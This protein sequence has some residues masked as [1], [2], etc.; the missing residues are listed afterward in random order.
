M[1]RHCPH[2]CEKVKQQLS[3]ERRMSEGS[4]PLA[5]GHTL[6]DGI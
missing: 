1:N 6:K 4:R 5:A 3:P 2:L